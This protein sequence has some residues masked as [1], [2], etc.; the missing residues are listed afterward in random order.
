M[1]ETAQPIQ[2]EEV[3]D[4]DEEE[5]ARLSSMIVSE[6]P[7]SDITPDNPIISE[8]DHT[9]YMNK[10][11]W[12]LS[13]FESISDDSIKV[14]ITKLYHDL[15]EL[16]LSY[17]PSPQIIVK[18]LTT[19]IKSDY[20]NNYLFY[21]SKFPIFF[22]AFE[23]SYKDRWDLIGDGQYLAILAYYPTLT[24][25]DSQDRQHEVIDLYGG[26]IN[27]GYV[28]QTCYCRATVT[29]TEANSQYW[30]SHG[31]RDNSNWGATHLARVC[32]GSS[33]LIFITN[34]IKTGNSN[35]DAMIELLVMMLQ[36]YFSY[37][38]S[39]GN[40]TMRLANIGKY[41][42]YNHSSI[43]ETAFI[44]ELRLYLRNNKLAT[45]PGV[46]I[47]IVNDQY[48]LSISSITQQFID[49]LMSFET[50]PKC[51]YNS[52]SNSYYTEVVVEKR[53]YSKNEIKFFKF[54]GVDIIGKT[55]EDIQPV[56]QVQ[57]INV[58]HPTTMLEITDLLNNIFKQHNKVFYG[59][60]Q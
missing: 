28:I 14:T 16:Q 39:D 52:D 32:L 2:V 18:A 44:K 15:A 3:F 6:Q 21:V 45:I 36:N 30:H 20:F 42:T 12:D 33:E 58:I 19:W 23:E 57:F 35:C 53:N 7:A 17:L 13:T 41:G 43:S 27:N 1:V 31:F 34:E 8:Q 11:G 26:V 46:G 54:R 25:T 50:V 29:R 24:I 9:A 49:I 5:F 22:K 56:E 47:I 4:F 10:F 55:I 37:E 60:E 48:E 51:K 38:N 40:P 59:K